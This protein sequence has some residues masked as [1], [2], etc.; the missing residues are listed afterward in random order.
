MQNDWIEIDEFQPAKDT[1]VV[2]VLTPETE[3]K[4][5]S[6]L[7]LKTKTDNLV[8]RPDAGIIVSVGPDSKRKVGEFVYYTKA[9]GYQLE[10]IRLPNDGDS[11]L[12]L[13]DDAI[14]GNRLPKE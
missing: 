6:G 12:L 10:M 3:T 4:S 2:K 8:D 9:S 5:E 14:I 13:Y 1:F 11:W 7:I